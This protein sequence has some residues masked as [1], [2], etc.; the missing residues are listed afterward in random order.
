MR[1]TARSDVPAKPI[2][3]FTGRHRW[4]SNFWIGPD[5]RSVEHT[6]QAAKVTNADVQKWVLDSPTPA[7]AKRRGRSAKV[8]AFLHPEWDQLRI[9]VMT[10]LI[11]AKAHIPQIMSKLMDTG[12]AHLE[13]GNWWGDEFWGVYNG[14]GLNH[15]GRIWMRI[16]EEIGSE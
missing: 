13:E 14:R 7:I 15:L 11:R 9:D 10:G 3:E 6:Y 1:T 4:L 8:T 12:D 2:L 5:G 16:R